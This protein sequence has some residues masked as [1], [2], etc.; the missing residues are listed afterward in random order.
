MNLTTCLRKYN[1][2]V[3]RQVDPYAEPIYLQSPH[4]LQ[5][6]LPQ[7]LIIPRSHVPSN[8][9]IYTDCQSCEDDPRTGA[10]SCRTCLEAQYYA[11]Q[12]QSQAQAQTQ[13]MYI[14]YSTCEC[15]H[16]DGA[17]NFSAL[18]QRA[19]PGAGARY[20]NVN[21]EPLAQQLQNTG[22][23][24]HMP[25]GRLGRNSCRD[26]GLLGSGSC[27]S[28][29][30]GL[31]GLGVSSLGGLGGLGGIGGVRDMRDVRDMRNHGGRYGIHNNRLGYRL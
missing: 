8:S 12:A 30:G 16:C 7:A 28:A 26:V 10:H 4:R 31:N 1:P 2:N 13:D 5:A 14:N 18:T 23:Y 6:T 25:S 27:F 17:L 20:A 24:T 15:P 9:Q 3:F 21:I 29:L 22:R 19:C 11:L